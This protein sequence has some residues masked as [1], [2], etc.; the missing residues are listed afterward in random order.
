[1][2]LY[3][4]YPLISYYVEKTGLFGVLLL[5]FIFLPIGHYFNVFSRIFEFSMGVYAR[6]KDLILTNGHDNKLLAYAAELSF[7]VFLF[8]YPLL[9]LAK[10]NIILFLG[11]TLLISYG[12]FYVFKPKRR[13]CS[14]FSFWNSA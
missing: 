14:S 8:H 3:L 4:F 6:K 10:Q 2:V 12:V 1:M 5:W 7:Y 13:H 11:L 9:F